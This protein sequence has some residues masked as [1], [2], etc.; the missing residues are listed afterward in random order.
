[1][2]T[3][4]ETEAIFFKVFMPAK[5]RSVILKALKQWQKASKSRYEFIETFGDTAEWE[6]RWRNHIDFPKS[7]AN[8]DWMPNG[9]HLITFDPRVRWDVSLSWWK[10]AF[11]NSEN[12]LALALHEI[13]HAFGLHHVENKMSIM[14]ENPSVEKI[15]SDSIK[16]LNW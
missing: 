15:D 14:D 6:F 1:M 10:L 5:Y 16:K 12:F 8:H 9:R 11:T 13:G 2:K 3:S 7:I 4:A